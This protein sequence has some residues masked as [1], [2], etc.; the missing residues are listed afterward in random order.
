MQFTN[1]E[2]RT[3]S[4]AMYAFVHPIPFI[5]KA[6]LVCAK[7]PLRSI[8]PRFI[9]TCDLANS[10]E[11]FQFDS[12]E[13]KLVAYGFTEVLLRLDFPLKVIPDIMK[14]ENLFKRFLESYHANQNTD[15][16]AAGRPNDK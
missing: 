4:A 5:T 1:L 10:L 7:E 12:E 15:C 6:M 16:R 3:I 11:E 13:C 8:L 2:W 14:D 9:L